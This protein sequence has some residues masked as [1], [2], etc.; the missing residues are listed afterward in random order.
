MVPE[1]QRLHAAL[2]SAFPAYVTGLF[3]ERGYALDRDAVDA[4]EVATSQLDLELADELGRPFLEQRRTPLE[5]FGSALQGLNPM[6]DATDASAP[7]DARPGD[8]YGLAPGSPE[9]LGDAVQAAHQRW[10]EAKATALTSVV[11]RAAK[12]RPGVVVLTMDRVARQRLCDA[13]ERAG[14]QCFG[15][16]NPSAVDNALA[17]GKIR[18]AFVDLAHRAAYESIE[19]LTNAD[20]PT[21]VFGATI[22]DLTETG[23]QAAG[24]TLVVE[25][26]RL[27][28]APED[29]LPKVA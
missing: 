19:R 6:L 12:Q 8:P 24:V 4:I 1:A 3:A 22:D 25:R 13:A 15:A 29:H 5:M 10:G 23:L 21:A 27:L 20:V 9:L 18:L 2:V 28:S 26:E 16:R 11:D 14:L 7:D 17:T